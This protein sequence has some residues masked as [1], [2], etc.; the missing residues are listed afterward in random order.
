[1]NNELFGN[2][3]PPDGGTA[4][5]LSQYPNTWMDDMGVIYYDLS[6]FGFTAFE[7]ETVLLQIRQNWPN[8]YLRTINNKNEVVEIFWETDLDHK[9]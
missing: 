6:A 8:E 4:A 2:W 3:P 1:M 9:F 7:R 5:Y